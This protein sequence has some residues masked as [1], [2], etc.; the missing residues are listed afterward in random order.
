[1]RRCLASD[2]G[3]SPEELETNYSNIVYKAGLVARA[4]YVEQWMVIPNEIIV[5]FRAGFSRQGMADFL[6]QFGLTEFE[7]NDYDENR[8]LTALPP[9]ANGDVLQVAAAISE[10]TQSIQFAE[11]NFVLVFDQRQSPMADPGLPYQWHHENDG[12]YATLDADLDSSRAWLRQK[13]SH[14]TTIAVI[15]RG[16]DISHPDLIGNLWTG[17]S[18]ERGID[19][20]DNDPTDLYSSSTGTDQFAHGTRAAGVAAAEGDNGIGYYGTC[21]QCELLLI[22]TEQ[23]LNLVVQ[24]FDAAVDSG[25]D[26]I[27]NSWGFAADFANVKSITDA[28]DNAVQ[29]NIPVVFAMSNV[30]WDNCG[31]PPDISAWHN[32]IA[33]SGITDYDKRSSNSGEASGYGTCMDVLGPT[34]GGAKGIHTPSVQRIS[35]VPTSTLWH[36]FGG[37]SA[38]APMVAGVIGLLKS[39]DPQLT[40]LEIQRILQDTADRVEPAAAKYSAEFGFSDPGGVPRHGYGRVNSVEA[41]MLVAPQPSALSDEPTGRGGK[42]LLLRDHRLDWGNT[43]EPSSTIFASPHHE[44][45]D[46]RSVDIKIDVAPFKTQATT[47]TEFAAFQHEDP[48]SGQDFRVYVRLRNRGPDAVATADLKLHAAMVADTYPDLPA[49]FW[50]R[51]PNDSQQPSD[52]QPISPTT[53]TDIRYSGASVAGCPSRNVPSC[54]P[55][56]TPPQDMAQIS[57]FFVPAMSWESNSATGAARGRAFPRRPCPGQTGDASSR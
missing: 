50:M 25:A 52:W 26:V 18:G 55:L 45:H 6:G 47:P 54:L 4:K 44:I 9:E 17:S 29:A 3:N 33:V 57:M 37:T 35:G 31:E 19:L 34:R 53:L 43:A 32:V 30:D 15:D 27:S 46:Y 2:C 42:D 8:V 5:K 23:E 21:P 22:R 49:D 10:E 12:A 24:A 28:I 7:F 51:F 16:F 56:V 13:G 20:Y 11:P 14:Q 39:T 36:D 38:A 41:T 1:M 40:P 48:V